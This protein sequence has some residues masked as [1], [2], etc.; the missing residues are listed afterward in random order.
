MPELCRQLPLPPAAQG[1]TVELSLPNSPSGSRE[2]RP[3]PEE[4]VSQALQTNSQL[5]GRPW[6]ESAL[7]LP[8]PVASSSSGFQ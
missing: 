2:T 3:C 6:L 7:S 5:Q 1:G 4:E 8:G